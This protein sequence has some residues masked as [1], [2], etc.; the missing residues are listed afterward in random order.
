MVTD[1]SQN[2]SA[3]TLND[4][5]NQNILQYFFIQSG[6]NTGRPTSQA[7][8]AFNQIWSSNN[9]IMDE[10]H[11]NKLKD[12]VYY[13]MEVIIPGLPTAA[14]PRSYVEWRAIKWLTH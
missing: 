9:L 4:M 6:S 5:L 2:S 10:F 14:V 12:L 8:S 13:V 3:T 7:I 1:M 11:K